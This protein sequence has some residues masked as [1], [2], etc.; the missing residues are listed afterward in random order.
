VTPRKTI[1]KI[2]LSSVLGTAIEWYDFLVY[3]LASVLVFNK[4]FFPNLSP[5]IGTIAALGSYGVGFFARPVGSI[6]FGYFGDRVGRKAT[7]SLTIIIMGIGTFL[8]GCLPTFQEAGILAPLSLITLRFL[9]GLGIGGER[10]GAVLMVIESA[11][12]QLRGYYGSFV[13]LGY[14]LGVIFSTGAFAIVSGLS[15][16]ELLSWGWRVPFLLSVVLVAIGLFI[17]LR[18]PETPAFRAVQERRE[19]SR[20]PALEVFGR[21]WKTMLTAAG[22]TVS[23]ISLSFIA[24]VFS[25]N[26]VTERLGVAKSTFFN[27]ILLASII[28]LFTLPAFGWLS[29]R[30]GRKPLYII[31]CIFVIL[32]AFPLFWLFDTRHW[33]VIII[34]ISLAISFGQSIMYA[35]EV[36][37]A[38]ELFASRLRYS[39]ASIG[40][41]TGAALT[42]GLTPIVAASLYTWSGATWPISVYLI[43]LALSSLAAA[44]A[45]PETAGN[46]LL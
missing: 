35:P 42:G 32:F 31:G 40:V 3:G 13:Q 10:G 29:D 25:L 12:A 7:L 38:A 44:S 15:E 6:I 41:Q 33:L 28:Q 37:W 46:E 16:T 27:G 20:M 45:A 22:L 1:R 4:L 30:Y 17:R 11:P 39:G 36:T 26:Y 24:T 14:P 5:A 2:I 43:V 9:Q 34:T 18:L 23:E 19:L 8:I 21:H